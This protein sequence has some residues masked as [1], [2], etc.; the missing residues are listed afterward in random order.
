MQEVQGAGR[1]RPAGALV[2][3]PSRVLARRAQSRLA[4]RLPRA[5]GGGPRRRGAAAADAA[6]GGARRGGAARDPQA[7]RAEAPS[8]VERA[9]P[10]RPGVGPRAR[11]ERDGRPRAARAARARAC[12]RQDAARRGLG[13]DGR[14]GRRPAARRRAGRH[15]GAASRDRLRPRHDHVRRHVARPRDRPAGCGALD[16]QRPA[17]V[18]RRRDLADQ[19]HDARPGRT[20]RSA[21]EGARDARDADRGGLRGG[22][23]R[24]SRGLRDRR[25]RERHDDPA[26]A[27]DRPRA[28]LDGAVHDR[29]AAVAGGNRRRPRR[30]GARA[31]PGRA[32]PGPGRLRRARHRGR[33]P[34]HRA[35][36]RQAP[37]ALHRRRHEFRDRARVVRR[38]AGDGRAGRPGVRGG[39]D[40]LRHA[41][42]RRRDRRREDRRGR[43]RAD[44][45]R[46]RGAGGALWLRARRRRRRARRGGHSRPLG[47]V[48]AR[49]VGT[50]REDRRGERLL[51]LG[52][53]LSLPARR[54]G[55]AIREGL[56]RHRLADPLQRHG[57]RPDRDL[58]R[59]CSA[60]RS[61]PT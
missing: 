33:H 32:L 17:A 44:G 4:A 57:R 3:R 47:P 24:P 43:G 55:A 22:G 38:C 61:A 42:R 56:D 13:R 54:A 1:L 9:H 25:R 14:R 5:G 15:D 53:D 52:R 60:A 49:L 28:A 20:R 58:P 21:L 48:R 12:A 2:G 46:R 26:R 29:R 18:R 34:R 37:A 10:R 51:P 39:A 30:A 50:S 41:G 23:C 19:R 45:D 8:R 35:H 27:R 11:R 59:C 36:A 6:E 31:R 7:G 40:P 16:P